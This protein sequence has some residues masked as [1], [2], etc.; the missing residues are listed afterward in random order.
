MRKQI[1]LTT[2]L[3]A[4][5]VAVMATAHAGD[6]E[7]VGVQS[8]HHLNIRD[9][10]SLSAKVLTGV[11]NASK[12]K[13]LGCKGDGDNKWCNVETEGGIKGFAFAKYLKE[14]AAAAA[15]PPA[16][17]QFALG[18]LKC[19]KN[20]GSPVADCSYG[21]MRVGVGKG[22]LQVIWPDATK[23]MFGIY[24]NIVTTP[25]GPATAK[26]GADG[27]YDITLTPKG[28]ASEHYMVPAG[29]ILAK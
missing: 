12:L 7:V 18:T 17:A 9:G 14:S 24:N 4:S 19:E 13:N 20:N 21:V 16:P 25:D 23:R 26:V 6:F 1:I 22:R 10:G 2:T 8:T 5:L 27:S 3:A 29:V 28:A 11:A 15:T